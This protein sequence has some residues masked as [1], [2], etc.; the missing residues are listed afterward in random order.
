MDKVFATP[1]NHRVHHGQNDYCIDVNYGG[2]LILWDRLFGTFEAERDGEKLTYGVR[3]PPVSLNPFFANFHYYQDPWLRTKTQKTWRQ[4]TA[5]WLGRPQTVS[6]ISYATQ[7]VVSKNIQIYVVLQGVFIIA[8]L[9][10]YLANFDSM[11]V[12]N[13]SA[14]AL[15]LSISGSIVTGKQIGR[16]HV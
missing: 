14:H 8:W 16:A 10:Y 11:N 13:A 15:G 3:T 12:V 5:V 4:K 7:V 9:V 2:I 6:D 1:S